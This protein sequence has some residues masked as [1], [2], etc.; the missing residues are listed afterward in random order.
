MIDT[1]QK[2]EPEL[3]DSAT[4]AAML[5]VSRK[6]IEKHRFGIAGAMKI[7]GCW[8]FR[9]Q[10]IRARLATGRDIILTAKK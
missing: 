5:S 4:L 3:I 9:V 6:F 7:G 8:R 1:M 2:T 10:V